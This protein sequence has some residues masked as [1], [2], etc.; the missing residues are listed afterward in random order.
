MKKNKRMV[1]GALVGTCSLLA[2]GLTGLAEEV[3]DKV[4]LDEDKVDS[5]LTIDND[6]TENVIEDIVLEDE[7]DEVLEDSIEELSSDIDEPVVELEDISY[8]EDNS[9]PSIVGINASL[10]KERTSEEYPSLPGFKETEEGLILEDIKDGGYIEIKKAFDDK[11][12]AYYLVSTTTN[13]ENNTN[14]SSMINKIIE[15]YKEKGY[16][17]QTTSYAGSN[18]IIEVKK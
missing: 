18:V 6:A 16:K 11:D 12:K 3:P 13:A 4:I 7:K 14:I 15:F 8:S 2:A 10:S 17:K 9:V 1:L 5:S